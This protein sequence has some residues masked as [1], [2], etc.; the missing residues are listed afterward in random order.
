MDPVTKYVPALKE[1]GYDGV[2]I[3]H[4]LQMSSGVRFNEDYGDY[5]SDINRMG[6]MIAFN[7]SIDEFVAS[8]DSERG[9]GQYNHYVSM[10]TQVLAMVLR[11]AA[12]TA[13]LHPRPRS[14][15]PKFWI[16]TV[17]DR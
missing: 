3:K 16:G 9:S 2:P 11:K 7:T 6:R 15:W 14:M 1:T 5:D 12:P 8:I 4:V 17:R 13:E 10:D